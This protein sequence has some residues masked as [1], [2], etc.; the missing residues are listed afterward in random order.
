MSCPK[1][2]HLL[3][4]YFADDLAPRASEE[5]ERHL[6]Q[7][8]DCSQEL[9]SLLL[10]QTQLQQWQEEKIPHWDRG[11]EQFR[12]DHRT[13]SDSRGW[14]FGWQWAPTAASFA[15]LCILLVNMSLTTNASG[16][17]LTFGAAVNDADLQ[18]AIAELREQQ[19]A[20][21]EAMVVRFEE[22]QDANNLQLM[23]AVM[24]Q[25]Q[26]TT[27]DNLD[28]IFAY[29]EEQRI[30]DMQLLSESYQQLADSDYATIQSLQDLAQFVSFQESR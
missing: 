29:F 4:E 10:A 13:T 23:Q 15:M 30:Q 12:R 24:T 5:I 16:F 22:R 8:A 18:D 7:C 21:F 3:Q 11:L 25:T 1:T 17:S 9:E 28:R 20:E 19:E 6:A 2:D 27:A 14:F 26:Q